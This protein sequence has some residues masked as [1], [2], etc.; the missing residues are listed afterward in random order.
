MNWAS[1]K[2]QDQ[3]VGIT[4]SC[5]NAYLAIGNASTSR[6]KVNINVSQL[7]IHVIIKF[8]KGAIDNNAQF[9]DQIQVL[10]VIGEIFTIQ[11]CN[12]TQQ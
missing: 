3:E 6:R 12:E 2:G 10:K 1:T 9:T 8:F 7:A 11:S 4:P 5:E